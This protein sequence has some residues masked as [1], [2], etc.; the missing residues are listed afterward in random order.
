MLSSDRF[1][2]AAAKIGLL[3]ALAF[4]AAGLAGCTVTPLYGDGSSGQA[5]G[6]SAELRTIAVKP[7]NTREAL[8]VR[9]NL[10]FLLYGGAGAPSETRYSL[11]LI[12]T[13]RT[14]SAVSI[15][16]AL[17]REP[18]AGEVL[19]TANYVLTDASDGSEVAKGTR[20]AVAA[21]DRPRQ[22]FAVERAERDAVDRAAR[23]LAEQLRL[24][25][26]ADLAQR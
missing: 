1:R 10:L 17:E 4:G 16:R 18:T 24:A 22:E 20:N 9:N 19:L 3:A 7:V 25:L 8:E 6:A 5:G 26:A 21:F 15:Q 2:R 23:E 13:K 12:V 14:S 11:T